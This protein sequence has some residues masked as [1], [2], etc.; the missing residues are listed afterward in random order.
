MF[1]KSRLPLWKLNELII[2]IFPRIWDKMKPTS[3]ET[4]QL[5]H[6]LLFSVV[7]I[8]RIEKLSITDFGFCYSFLMNSF[9]LRYDE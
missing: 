7:Y 5:K 9:C 4:L 3:T 8:Y 1:V 2:E 6:V